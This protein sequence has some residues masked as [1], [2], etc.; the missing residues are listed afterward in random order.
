MLG[1]CQ[2]FSIVSNL[3]IPIYYILVS[4]HDTI[5]FLVHN[6][7]IHNLTIVFVR[8]VAYLYVRYAVT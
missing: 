8:L 1:R 4:P 6:N 7:T 2:L 3:T 5:M